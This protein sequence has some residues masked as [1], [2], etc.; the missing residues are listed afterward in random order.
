MEGGREGTTN[1]NNDKGGGPGSGAWGQ[2]LTI[3]MSEAGPTLFARVIKGQCS[4]RGGTQ[5]N[6]QQQRGRELGGEVI[7]GGG[8]ER[9]Y[10]RN[11]TP[12]I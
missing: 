5:H 12:K 4:Y 9:L 10:E 6:Q 2:S 1:D 3:I 11:R 8:G 7:R